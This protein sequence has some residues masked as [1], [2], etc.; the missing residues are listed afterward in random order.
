MEASGVD[1][2]NASTQDAH[3]AGA[4]AASAIAE[5]AGRSDTTPAVA[6]EPG[7]WRAVNRDLS[8]VIGQRGVTAVL[9][10]A[11]RTTRRTHAWLPDLPG[12]LAFENCM[13]ALASAFSGQWPEESNTARRALEDTFH[14]QLVSLVGAGLTKELLRTD[15]SHR[16]G[17]A[18]R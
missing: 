18:A 16:A 12:D 10:R 4:I 2:E 15:W 3:L 1:P 5:I 9:G 11:L 17:G 14:D 6:W 8:P 13:Q 7:L